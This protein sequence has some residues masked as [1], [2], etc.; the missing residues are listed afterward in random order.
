MPVVDR[1]DPPDGRV[2][3]VTQTGHGSGQ[4]LRAVQGVADGP[5]PHL[6]TAASQGEPLPQ[7]ADRLGE[8]HPQLR[9]RARQHRPGRRVGG[10]HHRVS[11]GRL[12]GQPADRNPGHGGDQH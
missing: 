6:A 4:D 11:G 1:D 12:R 7:R 9:W 5:Q 10:N 3:A 8:D 2:G